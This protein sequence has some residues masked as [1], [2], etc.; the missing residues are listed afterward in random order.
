M[1]DEGIG[2]SLKRTVV[3]NFVPFWGLLFISL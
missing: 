1:Q 3:I 2:P